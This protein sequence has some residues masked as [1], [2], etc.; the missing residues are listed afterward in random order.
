VGFVQGITQRVLPA[1]RAVE[2]MDLIS[3]IRHALSLHAAKSMA[4][5]ITAM[6]VLHIHV[7]DTKK[8]LSSILS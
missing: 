7:R 4:V 8:C 3:F 5:S 1:A 6:N 2:D